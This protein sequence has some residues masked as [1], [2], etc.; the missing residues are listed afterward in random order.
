MAPTSCAHHTGRLYQRASP[1][2]PSTIQT[3]THARPLANTT[4]EREA[5][6]PTSDQATPPAPRKPPNRA[7]FELFPQ[8]PASVGPKG[9]TTGEP[10]QEEA[11]GNTTGEQ[12]P[13]DRRA[14]WISAMQGLLQHLPQWLQQDDNYHRRDALSIMSDLPSFW[15]AAGYASTPMQ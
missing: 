6:R 4:A 10:L 14:R 7:S 13:E 8:E 11:T 9:G 5:Y 2:Q 3:A 1:Q 12:I 15:P